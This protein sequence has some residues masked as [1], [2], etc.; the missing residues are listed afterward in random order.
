MQRSWRIFFYQNFVFGR[1]YKVETFRR[2]KLVT[3]Y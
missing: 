3:Y 1:N 2:Y